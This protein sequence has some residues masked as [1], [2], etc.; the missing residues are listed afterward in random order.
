MKSNDGSI[1]S[2]DRDTDLYVV[3]LWSVLFL[4]ILILLVVWEMSTAVAEDVNRKTNEVIELR[5]R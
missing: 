1:G 4:Q 2:K 3:L 5:Q